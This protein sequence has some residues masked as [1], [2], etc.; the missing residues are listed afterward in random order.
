MMRAEC[1]T[2]NQWVEG[3]GPW[4]QLY[5]QHRMCL[6][7]RLGVPRCDGYNHVPWMIIQADDGEYSCLGCGVVLV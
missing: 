1:K 6:G 5:A 3:A 4:C 7:R 2:C